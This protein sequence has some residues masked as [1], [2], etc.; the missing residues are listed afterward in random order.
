MKKKRLTVVALHLQE[1]RLRKVHKDLLQLW[2]S[3][4]QSP[5]KASLPHLPA[6]Y[7]NPA[8]HILRHQCSAISLT[9]SS[10]ITT[11][12]NNT[13]SHL[14]APSL[15]AMSMPILPIGMLKLPKKECPSCPT[16]AVIREQEGS[17]GVGKIP[18]VMMHFKGQSC[19]AAA[20]RG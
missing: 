16:R 19:C 11:L 7:I 17:L 18:P 13:H 2:A 6:F 12:N 10:L 5:A 9:G 15:N 8:Q 4:L 1:D 20:T 3:L 14:T